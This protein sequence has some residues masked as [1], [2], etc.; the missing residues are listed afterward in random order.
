VA[1][2]NRNLV[3]AITDGS[4]RQDLYYRLSAVTLQSPINICLCQ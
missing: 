2:T 1:A 3:E 4:F